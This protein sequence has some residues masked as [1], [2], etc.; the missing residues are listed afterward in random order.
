[1]KYTLILLIALFTAFS[2]G[3][4]S[5]KTTK[6]ER[7]E[8]KTPSANSKTKKDQKTDNSKVKLDKDWVAKKGELNLTDDQLKLL[9]EV[10]KDFNKKRR[11]ITGNDSLSE[12][13]KK[14]DLK[15]LKKLKRKQIK[16]VLNSEQQKK[17]N[18]LKG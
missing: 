4:D 14:A 1:M 17:W 3:T 8:K 10:E 2:C 18:D 6:P 9:S 13:K 5:K 7:T 11:A 16:V 12:A 15:E